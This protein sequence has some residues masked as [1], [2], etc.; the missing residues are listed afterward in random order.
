VIASRFHVDVADTF[1]VTKQR[2]IK[3]FYRKSS[4]QVDALEAKLE[5]V[6]DYLAMHAD[7]NSNA[8]ANYGWPAGM[9][10][11]GLTLRRYRFA[12][13]GLNGAAGQGRL[14]YVLDGQS[15]TATAIWLYNHAQ[16]AKRPPDD[17][18]RREV[19]RLRASTNEAQ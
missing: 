7:A 2:L 15:G 4:R 11:P 12:L 10:L 13:P 6:Y 3:Q 19:N 9:F 16:Y 17:E 18:I 8:F 5:G 14:M 1:E